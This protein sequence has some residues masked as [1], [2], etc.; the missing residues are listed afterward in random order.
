MMRLVQEL[1]P[2]LL[3][4]FHFYIEKFIRIPFMTAF[5]GALVFGLIAQVWARYSG[6][7]STADLI[8]AGAVMPFVPGIALTNAVR[9]IMT[10]HINSG[11]SKMFESLL[12]TLALGLAPLSPWF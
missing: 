7:P 1:Q 12:I 4:L 6:L 2:C 9:D 11:M 3:L 10:N 5:A 8:I